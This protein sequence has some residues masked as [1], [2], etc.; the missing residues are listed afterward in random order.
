MRV[1]VGILVA[2]LVVRLNAPQIEPSGDAATLAVR[3]LG[4]I[5]LAA[6]SLFLIAFGLKARE[7]TGVT[8][9]R[10]SAGDQRRSEP[11]GTLDL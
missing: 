7:G 3:A 11:E 4:S 6:L 9:P 5:C 10:A 1:A 2:I 8:S